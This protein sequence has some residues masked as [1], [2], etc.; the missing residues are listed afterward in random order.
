M[1]LTKICGVCG[2]QKLF[3]S[4]FRTYIFVPSCFCDTFVKELF[5]F[6]NCMFD[7]LKKHIFQASR[8]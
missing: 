3:K 1:N 7:F 5:K 2:V 8:N 4:I 6:P